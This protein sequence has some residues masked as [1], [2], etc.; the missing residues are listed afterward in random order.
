M[1]FVVASASNTMIVLTNGKHELDIR[2][3][4]HKQKPM[5]ATNNPDEREN[6]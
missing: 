1:P 3:N 2:N 6:S 5:K 4:A